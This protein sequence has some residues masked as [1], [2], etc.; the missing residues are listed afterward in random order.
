MIIVDSSV[1]IDYFNGNDSYETD[2]LDNLLGSQEVATGDLIILEVLRGFRSDSDYN[3]AKS[4][5]TSLVQYNMLNSELAIKATEYY[6][7]LRKKGI[8]VRKTAD[9]TIATFCIENSHSILYTDRDFIPFVDHLN[10]RSAA[11]RT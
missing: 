10:L 5:L 7:Q 8:T 2:V 3:T 11:T 6:R 4:H 9:V 1:W